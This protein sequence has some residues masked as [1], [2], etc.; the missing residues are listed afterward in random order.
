MTLSPHPPGPCRASTSCPTTS[1]VGREF[2]PVE[3][4][5]EVCKFLPGQVKRDLTS[6]QKVAMIKETCAP[7]NVRYETLKQIVQAAMMAHRLAAT[8]T[9][10][11]SARH[12]VRPLTCACRNAPRP[13]APPPARADRAGEQRGLPRL[14][15]IDGPRGAQ[16]ADGARA[17][18]AAPHV[19]GHQRPQRRRQPRRLQGPLEHAAARQR[20]AHGAGARAAPSA[21]A[22]PRRLPCASPLHLHRISAAS[23][24]R[25]LINQGTRTCSHAR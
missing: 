16:V 6:E 10:R 2:D 15:H 22:A 4:P 18:S 17:R 25:H 9:S 11:A 14:W 19:Q 20:A 7:P 24:P 8:T 21:S 1:Q 13:R 23:P 12:A 3:I 5:M